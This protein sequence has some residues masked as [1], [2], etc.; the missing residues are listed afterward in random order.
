MAKFYGIG[1]GPGDQDLLT[2]KAVKVLNLID[3]LLIPNTKKEKLG[4]AEII[5]SAHLKD[6][7]ERVYID[8]PMVSDER[9]FEEAG[10]HAAKV[11]E[12]LIA[13]GKNVGFVTLGDASVYSTYGYIVKAL[14]QEVEIETIP[15]ITSFCAAAALANRPLVEKDEILTIIPMNATDEQIDRALAVSDAFVFMKIYKREERVLNHLKKHGLEKD[16]I[17]AQRCGFKD[18]SIHKDLAESLIANEDYLTLV[19]S[20]KESK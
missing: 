9:V 16:G 4:V 3:V 11:I 1:V 12:P 19:L 15:G 17:L 13:S 6:S 20:R 5:V 18:A 7:I 10:N 8:F 14:S 2:L